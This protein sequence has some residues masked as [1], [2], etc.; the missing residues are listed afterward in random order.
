LI[1][2]YKDAE[3]NIKQQVIQ[4]NTI[5]EKPDYAGT[6]MN[7]ANFSSEIT[8]IIGQANPQALHAGTQK[9]NAPSQDFTGVMGGGRVQ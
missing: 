8:A 1:V 4:P 6:S 2:C 7:N 5:N 9:S 3:S